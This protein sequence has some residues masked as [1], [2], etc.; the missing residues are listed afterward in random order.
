MFQYNLNIYQLIYNAIV[1]KCFKMQLLKPHHKHVDTSLETEK[2]Q[3]IG[4]ITLCYIF[5]RIS[6]HSMRSSCD[7]N[8]TIRNA[9]ACNL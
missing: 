8:S 6:N 9:F 3:F 2:V 7:F 5:L 4:S 1:P